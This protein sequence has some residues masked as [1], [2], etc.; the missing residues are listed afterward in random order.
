MC[1]FV[2]VGRHDLI[3]SSSSNWFAHIRK[4][5]SEPPDTRNWPSGSKTTACTA[6]SWPRSSFTGTT[7]PSIAKLWKKR[8]CFITNNTMR[9]SNISSY[10]FYSKYCGPPYKQ[11]I[12]HSNHQGCLCGFTLDFIFSQTKSLLNRHI[13]INLGILQN[14][15]VSIEVAWVRR[16]CEEIDANKSFEV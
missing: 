13:S 15:I 8:N 3:H 4:V 5:L 10:I 2:F 12:Q 6:S 9:I 11:G 16:A 1:L 7:S 14:N